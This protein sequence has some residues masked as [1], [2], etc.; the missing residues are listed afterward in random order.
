[1]WNGKTWQGVPS[2]TRSPEKPTGHR[3]NVIR[4]PE[5]KTARIRAAF[6]HAANGKTGLTE[7]EAWGDATNPYVPPPSPAGNLALN[8][9]GKGYPK[10]SA[11][12]TSR[13]DKVEQVND[14][15]IV[16]RPAPHNRWT[17]YESPNASDWLEIDFGAK[18]EVGRVELYLYDDGGG[19]QAPEK[20]VVQF[21]N[22]SAWQDVP[23]QMKSPDR[24]AG[25]LPHT[26]T[27]PPVETS[28]VRVVF[29]HRGK[30]RSG[31]TE[32]EA[33]RE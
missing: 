25:R 21:W 15:R 24:P 20:Y 5:L 3:A 9:T 13:F 26:V 23:D 28:K 18:K 19:V 32:I 14:G 10:A 29:T 8:E 31:L 27:F 30:A 4:F 17:S 6:V 11:S 7:F 22:G 12:F 1:Y 2:Q 16:F 33:W